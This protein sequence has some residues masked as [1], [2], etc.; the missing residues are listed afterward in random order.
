MNINKIVSN[1]KYSCRDEQIRA[2]IMLQEVVCRITDVYHSGY[3]SETLSFDAWDQLLACEAVSESTPVKENYN[4]EE[5]KNTNVSGMFNDSC[6]RKVYFELTQSKQ[7]VITK[8]TQCNYRTPPIKIASLLTELFNE[9]PSYSG[10]W[11]YIAQ[12]Y[13]PRAILRTIIQMIKVQKNG[14]KTI[15]NPSAYFTILIKS[16]RKPRR[17]L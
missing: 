2:E 7:K 15:K 13:N 4:K 17:S 10:H 9:W 16:F 8:L 6:K 3:D 1:R 5:N 14:Q 12:K 11:L